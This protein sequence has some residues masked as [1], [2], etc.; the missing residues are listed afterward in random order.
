MTLRNTLLSSSFL[1]LA[2]GCEAPVEPPPQAPPLEVIEHGVDEGNGN[3]LAVQAWV[4]P[5]DYQ[6]EDRL[7][8]RLDALLE[9][10]ATR[11]LLSERTVVVL[12]EYVGT[13]L[14][15]IDEGEDTFRADTTSDAMSHVVLARPLEWAESY[16]ASPAEDA[17][18][19]ATFAVKAERMA[20]AYESV[21]SRLAADHAVTLVAGSL[22][23]PGPLVEEGHI[24]VTP[25]APLVNAAFVFGRDGALLGPPVVKSFPTAHEQPF[26]S[27]G[28]VVDL[29]VFDTPAGKLGV[30]VCADSWFPQA[31]RVLDEGGAELVAVPV[32]VA[33][34]SVW[35]EP[36]RGY[37]G[38]ALPDDVDEDDVGVL[39]EAEAWSKYALPGRIGATQARAGLTAP[40]R[41]TLWDVASD[42]QALSSLPGG[43]AK[44]APAYDG[45]L[46]VS[47][48][49]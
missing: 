19:Y 15:A 38:H 27:A 24:V 3:L 30:L 47:L 43:E 21:M 33:G 45:P 49:L 6:S 20:E 13:W 32:F 23:L 2:L 26:V 16:L 11:G 48:W 10:A 17:A 4:S 40:L 7:F 41:G 31:W 34:A 42:G 28:N 5:R 46:L 39:T 36:W 8:A 9:D 44:K 18:T 1:A 25:G 14:V 22:L 37:S 29:P 12:P 35:S